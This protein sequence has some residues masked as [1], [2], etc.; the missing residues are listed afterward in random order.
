MTVAAIEPEPVPLVRDEAG[1]LMVPGTRISLD[2]LVAAF[3]RGESPEAIH[4]DHE[5]VPL[6]DVYAIFSYYLRHRA[7]VEAY[8]SEQ[9]RLG[10]ELQTRLE[11]TYPPEGL[12]TKLLA[13]LR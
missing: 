1:R 11:E 5:I 3:K 13:P 9:L 8:L 6:A 2:I 4:D 7:E 12:R 10:S